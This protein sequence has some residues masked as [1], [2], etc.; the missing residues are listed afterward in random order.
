MNSKDFPCRALNKLN[1]FENQTTTEKNK[2][3]EASQCLASKQAWQVRRGG[4]RVRVAATRHTYLQAVNS[5]DKGAG[6]KIKA[7]FPAEQRTFQ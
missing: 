2:N 7:V 6:T 4:T 5:G 3:N 1:K